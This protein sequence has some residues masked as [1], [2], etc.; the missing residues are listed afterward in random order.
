MIECL[1]FDLSEVL[2]AG[3]VGT[4]KVLA[5]ELKIPEQSILPIFAGPMRDQL[6]MGYISEDDYLKDVISRG[7]W[8]IN[9][10][11]LKRVIRNNFRA[12]VKGSRALVADLASTY[13]LVLLSDHAKA[14]ITYIQSIHPFLSVFRQSF[15]S[16]ELGRIK[17]DPQ[18][19][20]IVLT[21]IA[22]NPKNCIFVD[23]NL[24]NVRVAE[25]VGITS[26]QFITADQLAEKLDH[27][28]V[29]RGRG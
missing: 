12:E 21:K 26:V 19:F 28:R 16:Y 17:S 5:R 1:I 20:R 29:G 11:V 22:V 18:T 7:G 4:E 13:H 15:F 27:V 8:K 10:G 9:I 6:F 2:I 23:D 3:L 24:R 14:W 25:S